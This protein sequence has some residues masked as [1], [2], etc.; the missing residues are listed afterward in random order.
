MTLWLDAFHIC[1]LL[2]FPNLDA[3]QGISTMEDVKQVIEVCQVGMKTLGY[4][5]A[6]FYLASKK[7][8]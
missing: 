6:M 7:H 8:S 3:N 2:K 1:L 5:S 4:V